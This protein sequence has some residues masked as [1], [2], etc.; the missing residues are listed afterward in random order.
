MYSQQHSFGTSTAWSL[1]KIANLAGNE[2]ENLGRVLIDLR[3][4]KTDQEPFVTLKCG[5]GAN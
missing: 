2:E 5:E 3:P 4:V 1:E